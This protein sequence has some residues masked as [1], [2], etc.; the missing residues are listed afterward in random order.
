MVNKYGLSWQVVP[1]IIAK[2]LSDPDP[3]RV[4]RV[5]EAV[6]QMK[7]LDVTKLEEAYRRPS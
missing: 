4:N 5:M 7:K 2:M 6:L 1:T 3:A